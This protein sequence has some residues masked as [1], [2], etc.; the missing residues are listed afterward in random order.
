MNLK[1]K[2][3]LTGAER[4]T[5]VKVLHTAPPSKLLSHLGAC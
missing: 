5:G 3:G 1:K 2:K 4:V